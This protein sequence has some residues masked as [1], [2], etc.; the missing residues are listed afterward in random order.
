MFTA[1]LQPWDIVPV[2]RLMGVMTGKIHSI[3]PVVME[4]GVHCQ[5]EW[6]QDTGSLAQKAQLTFSFLRALNL[7]R[8]STVSWRCIIDATVDRCWKPNRQACEPPGTSSAPYHSPS[9]GGLVLSHPR[10]APK[11]RWGHRCEKCFYNKS[12]TQNSRLCK[13]NNLNMKTPLVIDAGWGCLREHF[14][15]P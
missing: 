2:S 9:T 12:S 13:D 10:V 1:Q 11:I 8:H 4:Q 5:K 14:D 7:R 15:L 3:S 6:F